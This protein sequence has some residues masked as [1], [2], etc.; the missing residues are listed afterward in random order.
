MHFGV[1]TK[2]G[3]LLSINPS[4]IAFV[5]GEIKQGDRKPPKLPILLLPLMMTT[6]ITCQN[7]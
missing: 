3:G 6:M 1:L 7:V 5:T 2:L 4:E